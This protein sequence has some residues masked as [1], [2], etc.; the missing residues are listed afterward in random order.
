MLIP[1]FIQA[2]AALLTLATTTLAIPQGGGGGGQQQQNSNG[3]STSAAVVAT[4]I[5]ATVVSSAAVKASTVSQ[6]AAATGTTACNN[7]P[8]LCNRNYSNITHLGAHDSAFLRD[9]STS[10]STAGNQFYN[11]TVA[12][13][14]G[15]RLLQAQVHN[16]AGVLQLCHTSCTLLDGGTLAAWLAA[17]K[18]WMDANTNEVVTL[19][20][21]N[22][23]SNSTSSYGSVF[24]SSGIS[25]YGYTPASTSGPISTWPT[26][27][28]LITANT[29][30]VTFV[31]NIE[32][33]STYSYILPEFTYIFETAFEVTT[34]SG[35]NCS[36]ERPSGVTS[37]SAA[38]SSG[39]LSL[40][41]HFA[42][43]TVLS[44]TVPDISNI[45]TTNS[46]STTVTGALG[47]H[48]SLC[49]SEWGKKPVFMLVD[50]FNVGPSITTADNMN[51]I[52]GQTSGRT[53]VSTA[54]LTAETTSAGERG[55][56]ASGAIW[57]LAGLAGAV[58]LLF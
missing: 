45:A 30:L 34:L 39:Y 43:V 7:S 52:L 8:Q 40:M 57:I 36:L 9:S 19:L 41:N 44:F 10:F 35:F 13:N 4:A 31:T 1:S 46:A 25:K 38:I 50:F 53:N 37:S 54:L 21:V 5:A 51:G 49:N 15:V 55:V 20:L 23:D 28:T 16:K 47:T 58:F 12:L 2:S 26:L 11:A 32:Y 6:A 29:R 48:A 18:T 42:D 56:T 27:Q 22:S 14:A 24:S 33:S 17:I 3:V